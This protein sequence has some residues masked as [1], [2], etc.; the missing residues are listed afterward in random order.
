MLAWS[1]FGLDIHSLKEAPYDTIPI[2]IKVYLL[3]L[4]SLGLGLGEAE[5]LNTEL[6]SLLRHIGVLGSAGTWNHTLKSSEGSFRTEERAAVSLWMG[7]SQKR[8]SSLVILCDQTRCFCGMGQATWDLHCDWA[9]E[10][11]PTM[12]LGMVCR[13][14]THFLTIASLE[15]VM[16]GHA[17]LAFIHHRRRLAVDTTP[18]KVLIYSGEAI[19]SYSSRYRP[20]GLCDVYLRASRFSRLNLGKP[21]TNFAHYFS[22]THRLLVVPAKYG[23]PTPLYA[24]F[25]LQGH[26]W[27]AWE[28]WASTSSPRAFESMDTAKI[29]WGPSSL[30]PPSWGGLLMHINTERTGSSNLQTNSDSILKTILLASNGA[31]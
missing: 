19:L 17:V 1:C 24:F 10:V 29:S 23:L 14:Q 31:T 3:H 16:G 2:R 15:D 18:S 30:T 9:Y 6:I 22:D 8:L 26:F 5:Q 21:Q 25:F 13:Y 7:R 20:D 28:A 12:D 27:H 11:E 4:A